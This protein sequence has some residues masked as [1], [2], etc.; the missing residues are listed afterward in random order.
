MKK[1]LLAISSLF[2]LVGCSDYTVQVD[3][4]GVE[5]NGDE[6]NNGD[7]VEYSDAFFGLAGDFP[8]SI[9]VGD[10]EP[11]EHDAGNWI[12]GAEGVTEAGEEACE[13]ED[14]DTGDTEA[15]MKEVDEAKKANQEAKDEN[16]GDASTDDAST[17]DASTDDAST[18]DKTQSP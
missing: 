11:T 15:G 14:E 13:V 9:K 1:I 4:D 16:E 5:I 18:E 17:D 10:A 12:V 2:L 7:C 8:L 6:V 3:V